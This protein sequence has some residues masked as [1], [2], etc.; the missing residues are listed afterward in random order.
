LIS[1]A[2]FE[3]SWLVAKMNGTQGECGDPMPMAPGNSANLGWS[4]DRKLCLLEYFRS[5]TLP[6]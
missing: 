6:P 1:S 4:E 3:S 5:L 2:D